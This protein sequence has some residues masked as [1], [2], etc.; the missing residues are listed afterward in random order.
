VLD[1]LLYIIPLRLRSLFSKANVER[2]LDDELRYHID[3]KVADLIGKGITPEEALTVALREMGGVEQRKEECRDARGVRW[4]EDIFQDIRYGFRLLL[5]TPAF[6]AVGILTLALGIGANT[7]IY[8]VV[9]CVLLRALPYPQS[10]RLVAL[11]ENRGDGGDSIAYPNYLDWRA[12]Q[13]TF[14]DLAVYRRDDFNLTGNGEPERYSGLFVTASYFKVLGLRP[15]LGRT[16]NEIEDTMPGSNPLIL[17]EHLW[18]A[19]FGSDPNV[20]G[21]KLSLN[22]IVYEV[23]GVAPNSLLTRRNTDLYAP[24]GF[25][26]NRPY[27][28][29]RSFHGE[30][31]GVGRLKN[32]ISISQASADLQVIAH[33]LEMRYPD[34]NAGRGVKL[35]PLRDNLVGEYRAMLL[36]LLSAVALVLVITCANIATLLLARATARRKEIALRV[37]LGATRARII[38]Q[39]LTESVVL[40]FLGGVVGL[41]MAFWSK[42]AIVALTPRDVPIFQ[43]VTLDTGVLAFA[44]II[45]LIAGVAFGVIPAWQLSRADPHTSIKGNDTPRRQRSQ[46]WLVASQIALACTLLV[47]AGA[48]VKSFRA[49]Q[50]QPVGFDPTHVLTIG[51]KL[52]GMKYKDPYKREAFFNQLLQQVETLP[53]VRAAAI[54]SNTPFLGSGLIDSFSVAGRPQPRPGDEPRAEIVT[55]SPDYFRTMG[56]PLLSGR[57]FSIEDALGKPEVVLIDENLART[58]FQSQNPIGQQLVDRGVDNPGVPATI[59]GVVPIVRDE[60]GAESSVLKLYRP[61]AQRPDVQFTLL[62]RTNGEPLAFLP[63]I[64]ETIRKLD[65][66]LPV[67]AIRSM[68]ENL[69]TS[70][71]T[72]R[73]SAILIGIFSTLALLLAAIGLYGVLAY[74]VGQRTREI[75][76]RMALGATRTNI[77]RLV[78]RQGMGMVVIGLGVGLL[79]SLALARLLDRFVYGVTSRDPATILMAAVLLCAVGAMACWLPARRATHVDPLRALRQE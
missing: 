76:I 69:T 51:L 64:K 30:F 35:V 2:E 40:S 56:I 19:R 11:S 45:T 31:Y 61:E 10:D 72:Q 34:S 74:S 4:I 60:L 66:D 14:D 8:S 50:N 9:H 43:D 15:T 13:H 6:T 58:F 20:I 16:F 41:F 42:D 77:L 26:A 7:A 73:L 1:R 79:F 37:A 55:V 27:L 23:V 28:H 75:G 24:L 59:I 65:G 36:L 54:G 21:R 38:V 67:F 32:G 70:L 71:G 57:S 44:A 53:G 78:V 3:A 17:S 63:P 18:R 47:G 33:N 48:L 62:I 29:N 22:G 25:Y 49:L 52:P 68:E 39:L 46:T 12:G 5:K